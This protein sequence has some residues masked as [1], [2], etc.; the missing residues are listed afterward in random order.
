VIQLPIRPTLTVDRLTDAVNI[1][2][3][4][5]RSHQNSTACKGVEVKK[6]ETLGTDGTYLCKAKSCP[7]LGVVGFDF[8]LEC[9]QKYNTLKSIVNGNF[10]R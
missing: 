2:Y 6:W 8:Q 4:V 5:F 3:C 7:C 1:R 10:F 9:V